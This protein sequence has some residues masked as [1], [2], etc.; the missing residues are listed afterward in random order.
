MTT[1]IETE[2][3]LKSPTKDFASALDVMIM[4]PLSIGFRTARRVGMCSCVSVGTSASET[5]TFPVT[6][7][8]DVVSFMISEG[9]V[10]LGG[11]AVFKLNLDNLHSEMMKKGTNYDN[12]KRYAQSF[13]ESVFKNLGFQGWRCGDT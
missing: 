8:V 5:S 12:W 4:V 9:L 3:K 6:V 10:P 11:D 13:F 2:L 1:K 7:T